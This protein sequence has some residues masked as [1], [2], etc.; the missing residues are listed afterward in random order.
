MVNLKKHPDYKTIRHNSVTNSLHIN[1]NR[2]VKPYMI[3]IKDFTIE[4][5]DEFKETEYSKKY[6]E[7]NIFNNPQY[8]LLGHNGTSLDSPFSKSL[9]FNKYETWVKINS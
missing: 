1:T 8:H 4:N 7:E 3:V 6:L 5:W 9:D 2:Q